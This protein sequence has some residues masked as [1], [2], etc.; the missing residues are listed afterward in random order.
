MSLSD[1]PASTATSSVISVFK[2]P[3]NRPKKTGDNQKKYDRVIDWIWDAFYGDGSCRQF[4]VDRACFAFEYCSDSD[5]GAPKTNPRTYAKNI[6]AKRDCYAAFNT[7]D[8]VVGFV[9]VERITSGVNRGK[10]N[11]RGLCVNGPDPEE[12]RGRG[13]GTVLMKYVIQ[14]Y[15]ERGLTLTVVRHTETQNKV[16]QNVTK[17]RYEKLV[18]FYKSFGFREVQKNEDETYTHMI[19]AAIP[20]MYKSSAPRKNR[21][22]DFCQKYRASAPAGFHE[23]TVPEQGRMLGELWRSRTVAAPCHRFRTRF[24][25]VVGSPFQACFT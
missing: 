20:D 6:I 19:L 11:V 9:S 15:A 3:R 16:A 12:S 24:G 10:F 8:E 4:N 13:V 23:L 18:R 21:Y 2:V 1:R 22:I 17:E 5:V 7:S 14:I 25:R